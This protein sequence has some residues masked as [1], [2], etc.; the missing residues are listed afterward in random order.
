ML[1]V[2]GALTRVFY[3][4]PWW[5]PGS[6]SLFQRPY[7]AFPGCPTQNFGSASLF[8]PQV[9]FDPGYTIEDTPSHFSEKL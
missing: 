6:A 5:L 2:A 8:Q 3:V 7:L 9:N 4:L 1:I